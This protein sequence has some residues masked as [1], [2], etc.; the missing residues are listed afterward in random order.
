MKL[1]K[2]KFFM[3][4]YE[5]KAFYSFVL[6][7]NAEEARKIV[8]ENIFTLGGMRFASAVEVEIGDSTKLLCTCFK[9][10]L[11]EEEKEDNFVEGGKIN[12]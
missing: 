12:K 3:G 9:D 5:E 10:D 11:G 7:K 1:W 2:V 6:A 8:E 4:Q